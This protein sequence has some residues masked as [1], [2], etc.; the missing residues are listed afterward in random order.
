M[1]KNVVGVHTNGWGY[2]EVGARHGDGRKWVALAASNT[3]NLLRPPFD[4]ARSSRVLCSLQLVLQ[5]AVRLVV[6]L[7]RAHFDSECGAARERDRRRAG[8]APVG[9][10]QASGAGSAA[11]SPS[12]ATPP[13]PCSN[14]PLRP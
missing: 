7:L 6:R 10:W 13:S 2:A 3:L 14:H 4:E 12:P 9:E 8:S 11:T 5:L 1:A